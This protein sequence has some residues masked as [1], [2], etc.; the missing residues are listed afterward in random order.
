MVRL[1][2]AAAVKD[3]AFLGPPGGLVLDGREHAGRLVRVGSRRYRTLE[4]GVGFNAALPH[5]LRQQYGR[6]CQYRGWHACPRRNFQS[7]GLPGAL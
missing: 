7:V 3:G 2:R 4:L 1:P 6:A 5:V